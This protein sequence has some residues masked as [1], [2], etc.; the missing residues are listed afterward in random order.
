MIDTSIVSSNDY[1]DAHVQVTIAW[2][3]LLRN[4]LLRSTLRF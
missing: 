3:K 4:H 2:R 1:D